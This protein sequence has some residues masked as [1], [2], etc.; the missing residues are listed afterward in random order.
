MAEKFPNLW[1]KTDMQIQEAQR[2]PNKILTKTY[3]NLHG[4]RQRYRENLKG[5][6]RKTNSYTQGDLLKTMS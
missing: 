3:Y 6:K 5:N 1:K 2:V 4:K